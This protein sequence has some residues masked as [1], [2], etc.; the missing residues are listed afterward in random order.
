MAPAASIA[1][2]PQVPWSRSDIHRPKLDPLPPVPRIQLHDIRQQSNSDGL[3][4]QITAG[5]RV[6][7]KVLPSLLLW[8]GR[9]LQLFDA[10][11]D[12]GKYYPAKRE[13][14]LL[15]TCMSKVAYR[16]SPGERIIELGAGYGLHSSIL[17]ESKDEAYCD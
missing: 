5:L 12:S 11:L 10:I 7:E 1:V 15:S 8:N 4:A 9:G 13:P 2:Q 3:V 17:R 6:G 14:E 16:I